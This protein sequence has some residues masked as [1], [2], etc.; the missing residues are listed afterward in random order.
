MRRTARQYVGSTSLIWVLAALFPVLSLASSMEPVQARSGLE[1]AQLGVVINHRDPASVRA[2]RIYAQR[3]GIPAQNIV[4]L[5]FDPGSTTLHPGEFALL[6]ARL[7]GELPESVQAL[8][9]AWTQPYRVGC[10]SITS[11]FALGYDRTYCAQGCKLTRRSA[12]AGS[13]SRAPWDDLGIR[14]AMMLAGS[15]EQSVLQL[16]E[17]GILA[18][19]SRPE[20]T[21]YL[22]QTGDRA[23]SVRAS[24]YA[25]VAS[26]FSE[27]VAV[28]VLHTDALRDRDDVMIYQTGA[29][30]VPGL[31]SNWFLPGALADHL[32]SLGGQLTDSQQ[33]SALRWLDAGAT[34]SYGTVVEPCNF[35]Q[36]FPDVRWLLRSYLQGETAI[37]AYWKSV[38]MPGQGVFIGEPLARPWGEKRAGVASSRQE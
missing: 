6:K 14:P 20:G 22:V 28:E 21:V 4:E 23:R 31:R 10:M 29:V 26:E 7:D 25:A 17:R 24:Q 3:R 33:M 9:L 2:G 32:T 13:D 15:D 5:A 38:Q 36:K 30:D 8:A 34:G 11:A 37:E 19:G 27:Q 18:D 16:I 12:Y 35:P 1:P